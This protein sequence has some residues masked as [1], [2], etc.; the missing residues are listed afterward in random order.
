[1]VT[2]IGTAVALKHTAVTRARVAKVFV[3]G[4]LLFRLK[5]W[6]GLFGCLLDWWLMAL[7]GAK[8]CILVQMQA[9]EYSTSEHKRIS[10][11]NQIRFGLCMYCRVQSRLKQISP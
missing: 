4:I 5:R 11:A 2:S 1:M 3:Q 7:M 6:Q 9:G 8:N 10:R